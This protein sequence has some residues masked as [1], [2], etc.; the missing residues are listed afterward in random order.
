MK[1]LKLMFGVLRRFTLLWLTQSF[2]ALGTSMT[3]FALVIWS[4]QQEGSALVTALLSVCSYAPYVIRIA[5]ADQTPFT[6]AF[7]E[8]LTGSFFRLESCWIPG[9]L[10]TFLIDFS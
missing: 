9:G 7:H 5:S 1:T 4:Y 10:R 3:A 2:S 8:A 6:S